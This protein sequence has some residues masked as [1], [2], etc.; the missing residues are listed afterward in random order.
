MGDRLI[1]TGAAGGL[2]RHTA[3][4]LQA[5][6]HDVLGVDYRPQPPDHPP[7]LPYVQANYNKTRIEDAIRRH[8]PRGILHLGRVGNLK[9]AVG[10][11]FDLNVVGSG[12]IFELALKYDVERVIVLSTF[13]IY[14]AHPENHTP[15]HEDEPLRSGTDFPELADAVQLDNLAVQWSYRHRQLRTVILRPCNV[16]GPNVQNAI[17]R[18]LREPVLASIL[19]FDPMW[20]FIHQTDMVNAIIHA[21][22]GDAIGVFNVAGMGAVPFK[23][24]LRL[25]GKHVVPIPAP[26]ATGLLRLAGRFAPSLPPYLV[27]FCKYPVIISDDAFRRAFGYAPTIGIADSIASTLTLP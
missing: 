7:S 13:H 5:R 18:Y 20:Q 9:M 6:G 11:R 3:L 10:K 16:I 19:G 26:V 2:A 25:T 1:V 12:K 24:A 23:Q 15:I 27:D 21:L 4:M 22:D 17:S 14:G 8:K